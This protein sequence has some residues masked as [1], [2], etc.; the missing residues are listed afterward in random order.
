MLWRSPSR[1][2]FEPK[3][4]ETSTREGGGPMEAEEVSLYGRLHRSVDTLNPGKSVFVKY[5]ENKV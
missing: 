2:M 3:S 5:S 1:R 4:L